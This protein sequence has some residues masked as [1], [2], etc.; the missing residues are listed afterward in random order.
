VTRVDKLEVVLK[1]LMKK[2][3]N[4]SIEQKVNL[5]QLKSD[6][7][8]IKKNDNKIKGFEK[9]INKINQALKDYNIL[10]YFKTENSKDNQENEN[11]TENSNFSK[12]FGKKIDF[13]ETKIKENEEEI[14]K[15]KKGLNDSNTAINNYKKNYN[16]IVLEINSNINELKIKHNNDINKLKNNLNEN[17]RQIKEEM[18]NKYSQQDRKIK[19]AITELDENNNNINSNN[20]AN[21]VASK[22]NNEK[23]NN[24]TIELK[25]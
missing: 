22:V 15:L 7:A 5:D 11:K 17:I 3:I 25:N 13:K 24:I 18:G 1:E 9:N 16:D 19:D 20:N 6:F 10:D 21:F 23:L 2:I 12:M 8:N 4:T 14:N